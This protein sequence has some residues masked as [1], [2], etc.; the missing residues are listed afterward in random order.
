MFSKIGAL[1]EE[2]S[3]GL[4]IYG[5]KIFEMYKP[6]RRVVVEV[7]LFRGTLSCLESLM[8]FGRLKDSLGKTTTTVFILMST[9]KIKTQKCSDKLG[10]FS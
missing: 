6:R 2:F 10:L 5:L 7:V 3:I 4:L 9:V 1:R 8:S